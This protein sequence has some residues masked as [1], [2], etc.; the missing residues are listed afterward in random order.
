MESKF[1]L[2]TYIYVK[3]LKNLKMSCNDK[4]PQPSLVWLVPKCCKPGPECECICT[5]RNCCTEAEKCCCKCCCKC[6]DKD[7]CSGDKC[8]CC[9]C[10][11][12]PSCCTGGSECRCCT[13]GSKCRC[14]CT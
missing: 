14:K 1:C 11:K 10:A 2:E 9:K 7:C 12:K 3:K 6:T 4:K 8:C 5:D 13:G